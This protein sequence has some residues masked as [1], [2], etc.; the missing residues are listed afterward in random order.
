MA[1]QQKKFIY[2][3]T[4]HEDELS[5]CQLEMRSLFGF[6]TDSSIIETTV[7]IDPSRSP[8]INERIDVMY[9]ADSFMGIVQ[10]I[11]GLNIEGATFKVLFIEH[12]DLAGYEKVS[13]DER[14]KMEREIGL[15]IVGRVDLVNP[16]LLFVIMK[17]HNSWVFGQYNKSESIWFYHQNKPKQ[18]ST[19]LSTRVARAVVNIAVPKVDNIKAIDPCCGSGTVLVEA[20]S[21]GINI[22]GSD[23]NPLVCPLAREN[24]AYFGLEGEVSLRD[25][26]DVTG[27]YD[28]AIID[29]PYNLC[30]VL[31]PD[32]QLDMLRS[33]RSFASRVVVVTI[34]TID[35]LIEKAGFK[36][37]DRGVA[38]KG[39]FTRQILV[40][41]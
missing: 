2:T 1:Q 12:T 25:I 28:V 38:K 33:A 17:L 21:M 30:S 15:Q 35:Y 14:R 6:D 26:L 7:K 3:F 22:V 36:I 40:C 11:K 31:D 10:Q 5:L 19:A 9:R 18:Y 32:K 23:N 34:E 8:F 4:S 39:S 37:V 29:M 20:L 13:F 27:C 16:E 24:I 41:E